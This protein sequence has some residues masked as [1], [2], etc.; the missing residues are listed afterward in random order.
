M[1]MHEELNY[2]LIIGGFVIGL[3]FGMVC[4]RSKFCVVSAMSNLLLI[5]DYRQ[6]HAYLAA[7]GIALLGVGVFEATHWVEIGDSSYRNHSLNWL[8]ALAGGVIFG[9]G[10]MRAGGCAT[11]TVVRSA[12]GNLGAL[13]TL[14]SFAL[15]AMAANFGAL[16][17]LIGWMTQ[18]TAITLQQDQTSLMGMAGLP[19]WSL[20][21]LFSLACLLAVGTIGS[22][23]D[24]KGLVFAG[25]ILGLLVTIAWWITGA[26]GQDEFQPTA[27]MSVA[28]AAPLSRTSLYLTTGQITGTNFYLFLFSGLVAGA[29]LSAVAAG[30]FRWVAPAGN[31][32][33]AYLSGGA[34]M[35]LGA[36]MAGGCNIGQG[37]TGLATLSSQSVLAVIGITI[38]MGLVLKQLKKRE[39]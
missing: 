12:E 24:Y 9:V 35:G 38:G 31:Q 1:F 15:V 34:L 18:K 8:G 19:A 32:I 37:L 25:A 29:L 11:R 23:R 33:G 30:E 6:L 21:L 36:T 39:S 22:W 27:P 13:V 7:L 10:A 20:P 14:I 16:N 17:P 3:L 2:W 26:A 4:Q 5:R 28:I